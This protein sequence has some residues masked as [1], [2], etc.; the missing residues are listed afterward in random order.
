M[1]QHRRHLAN[2]IEPS[3]CGGDVTL[4]QITLITCYCC[5]CCC[6][7]RYVTFQPSWKV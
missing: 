7:V 4:C 1:W 2:T 3:T 6:R 5:R